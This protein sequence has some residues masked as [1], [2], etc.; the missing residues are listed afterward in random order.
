MKIHSRIHSLLL[1]KSLL[2]HLKRAEWEAV[3]GAGASSVWCVLV[4][5][6]IDITTASYHDGGFM[7]WACKPISQHKLQA[8][9]VWWCALD[10]RP[11]P[12]L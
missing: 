11:P 1:E 6:P 9:C 12:R 7:S 8:A 5:G 4:L 3:T 2:S 10:I